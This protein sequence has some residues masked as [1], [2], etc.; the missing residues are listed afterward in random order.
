MKRFFIA[1]LAAAALCAAALP[2][3]APATIHE[4]VA[5][6]CAGHGELE[7]P[8]IQDGKNFARPVNAGGVVSVHPF[9]GAAGPGLLVDIDF[10]SPQAKIVPTGRII[11]IGATPAGPLYLEE[12]IPDPNFPA[13]SHCPNFDF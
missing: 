5:Q 13:F 9:T 8:G 3:A 2:A 4:I 7:P 1:A 11:I 10:A 12:F 6:W